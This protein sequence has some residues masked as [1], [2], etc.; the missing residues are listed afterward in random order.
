M[1][2]ARLSA[3]PSLGGFSPPDPP[4]PRVTLRVGTTTTDFSLE[5]G[6]GCAGAL[7]LE[8]RRGAAYTATLQPPPA[9]CPFE[10]FR[11][12]AAATFGV[13]SKGSVEVA[14]RVRPGAPA[15]AA[16]GVLTLAIADAD[17][18][19]RVQHV[20][21]KLRARVTAVAAI[22]V[23]GPGGGWREGGGEAPHK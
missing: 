2:H 10:F 17:G 22:K 3:A 18:R 5:L 11:G 9:G 12:G 23:R 16:E 19:G 15:G 8:N 1:L 14:V 4:G 21:V 20:R 13:P 6:A 7:E